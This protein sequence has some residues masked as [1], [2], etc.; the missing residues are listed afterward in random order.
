MLFFWSS[1]EMNFLDSIQRFFGYFGEVVSRTPA[2][3]VDISLCQ[4]LSCT[5]TW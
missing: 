1:K 2:L 3:V 4:F 5:E